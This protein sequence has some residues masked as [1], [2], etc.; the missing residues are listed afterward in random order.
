M[1]YYNIYT[2]FSQRECD[3]WV[4]T[5][6]LMLCELTGD[7]Y[8]EPPKRQETDMSKSETDLTKTEPGT[9]RDVDN[10]EKSEGEKETSAPEKSD[11][12]KPTG[13]QASDESPPQGA[14]AEAAK[15]D[16]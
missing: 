14:A 2:L 7:P 9:A 1:R 16:R 4:Y 8:P 6:Q 3:D 5:A 15:V 13:E 10:L 11:D 12:M